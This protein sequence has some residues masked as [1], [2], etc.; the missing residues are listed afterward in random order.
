MKRITEFVRKETVFSV[1][2]LLTVLSVFLNPHPGKYFSYIDTGVL[3]TLFSLMGISYGLEKSGLFHS[4]GRALVRRSGSVRIL[5]ILLVLLPFFSSALVT[6]DVA[7]IMFIPF[8]L[9]LVRPIMGVRHRMI[10]VTLQTVA[11]NLG[12]MMLPVGNPQNLYLFSYYGLSAGDFFPSVLPYSAVSLLLLIISASVL[13][14]SGKTESPGD[15]SS[16][17]MGKGALF[18]ALLG[19]ALVSVFGLI[20][21]YVLFIASLVAFIF[22]LRDFLK[23][24]DYLLLL[25]FVCFFIF[26]GNLAA[27]EGVRAFFSSL[28]SSS[29]LLTTV[30]TCQ[31]ISNVP[32]AVL[33]SGFT[34]NARLLLTGTNIGGLGTPVASL[35]SLITIKF[36]LKEDGREVKGF[37][38]TFII[39]NFAFL[40]ILMAAAMI[41]GV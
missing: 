4:L 35:A 22:F 16:P 21:D 1:S 12:S 38:G 41:M 32:A 2:L 10:L 28:L 19:L 14:P 26:S 17:D 31:V 30:M 9:S 27:S 37:W 6:N 5:A 8:T 18:L 23:N 33:L 39:F 15:V 29:P 34:E 11:A 24:A 20:P 40:I 25:T 3:M 13:F 7:L 36:V